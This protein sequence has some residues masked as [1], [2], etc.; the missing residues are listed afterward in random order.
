[1]IKSFAVLAVL[2]AGCSIIGGPGSPPANVTLQ[3]WADFMA[4]KPADT[5]V[6]ARDLTQGG[7]WSGPNADNAKIAFLAGAIQAT[8]ELPDQEPPS[9][10]VVWSDGT[11][12]QMALTSAKA[13]FAAMVAELV[14]AGGNCDGCRAL[15]VTGAELTM[16]DATTSHGAA[17][18]PVWQFAFA[19]GDE[20]IDPIS[21]VALRDRIGPRDW[22]SWGDHAPFTEAAYATP[23]DAQVTIAFTGG[24]CDASHSIVAVESAVAIV[25]VISTA[26]RP[27]ACTA[28][29]ILYGLQVQLASPLGNRVVLDP[30][31]GFP[32]P[33]Y[34][35]DPPAAL[36][37]G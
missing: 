17:S 1:M 15:R 31:S 7:G 26:A 14:A 25:P 37:P 11:S 30:D 32:I 8:V 12:Q 28:Q 29:G 10:D 2:M 36:Q 9:G 34:P 16:R 20:P 19:P 6:F 24:A 3:R 35:E 18:V 4:N 33:V 21:Y 5:I 23:V 22:P 13:A 27:G